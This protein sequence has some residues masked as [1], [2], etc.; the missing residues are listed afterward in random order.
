MMDETE[1]LVL[2]SCTTVAE[3]KHPAVLGSQCHCKP[4]ILPPRGE[5]EMSSA[6][7]IERA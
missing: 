4:S 7:R 1:A 5:T 6:W 3:H 2:G